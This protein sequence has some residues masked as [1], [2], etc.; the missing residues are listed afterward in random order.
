MRA[1]LLAKVAVGVTVAVTGL[2]FLSAQAGA[3]QGAMTRTAARPGATDYAAPGALYGVAAASARNAWA[4]GY[5]GSESDRKLLM[6]HWNG[7][8]WTRVTS[9]KILDG[10]AGALS[11]ITV[12]SAKDAWAVG[13]TGGAFGHALVLH[14]NGASWSQAA[15]VPAIGGALYGVTATASSGWAV[16]VN[17]TETT[18]APLVLHWNGKAWSRASVKLNPSTQG[19]S[20]LAGVAVTAAKTAWAVG[21]TSQ[22]VPNAVLARWSGGSWTTDTS[23]PFNGPSERSLYG[24]ATGPG[25]TALAVGSGEPGSFG[26]GSTVPISM[27]WTG[28]KWQNAPVSAPKNSQFSAVAFAPGGTGWATGYKYTTTGTTGLIW[29]WTGKSWASVPALGGDYQLNGLGFAAAGNGWAVGASDVDTLI[30]HWN[31]HSWS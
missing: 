14:W 20:I 26:D 18:I 27:R 12:V 29:R 30:L 16:G 17:L 4:V 10:T 6:L 3:A 15:N 11:A 8:S 5:A 21:Y 2:S 24:V 31:G 7:T 9:P 28:K 25:G 1:C 23:F 13:T 22:G 19:E